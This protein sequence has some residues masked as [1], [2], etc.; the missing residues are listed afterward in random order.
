MRLPIEI[1]QKDVVLS[2]GLLRE[3]RSHAEKLTR[4]CSRVTRCRV[5][6]EGPGN[7]HRHGHYHVTV[8]VAV[9]RGEIVVRK[10]GAT[11]LDLALWA[12]FSAVIRRLEDHVQRRRGF[13]KT[14]VASRA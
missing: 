7:H 3:I 1:R 11:S 9:P 4:F 2:P 8:D 10:A 12:A 13:V 6:V 14:K 5:W